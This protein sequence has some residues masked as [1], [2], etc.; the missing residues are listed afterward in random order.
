MKVTYSDEEVRT[1]QEATLNAC[2]PDLLV[3]IDG[4]GKILP[5]TAGAV[6]GVTRTRLQ[7][8]DPDVAVRLLGCGGSFRVTQSGAIALGAGVCQDPSSPTEVLT[9][10]AGGLFIGYKVGPSTGG[11]SG[12]I[13]EVLDT[14]AGASYA[15]TPQPASGAS[16][17]ATLK[18]VLIASGIL[19]D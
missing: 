11:A 3:K 18:T 1:F 6:E 10:Y 7:A 12:D 13:I 17:Y 15:I 9:A 14:A 2:Q 19:L 5:A 4:N 8:G 16:D